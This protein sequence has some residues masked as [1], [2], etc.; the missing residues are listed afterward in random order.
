MLGRLI[1]SGTLLFAAL[2]WLIGAWPLAV[3]LTVFGACGALIG[4]LYEVITDGNS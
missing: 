1:V 4:A 2:C 3:V